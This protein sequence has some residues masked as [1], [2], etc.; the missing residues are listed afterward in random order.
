[1]NTIVNARS[2]FKNHMIDMHTSS[3]QEALVSANIN[4]TVEKLTVTADVLTPEG[5]TRI[6]MPDNKGIVARFPDEIRPFRTVGKD[7]EVIQNADA[8]GPLQYLIGEG[9][10]SHITQAG[11]L[12]GGRKVFMLA[13][14]A[15]ESTLVDPHKRMVL[16]ATSHDGSGSLMIKGW[17]KR[18]FCANQIPMIFSNRGD[19]IARIKHS[20]G[21]KAY[22]RQS[23]A[24]VT[25]SIHQMEA[26]EGSMQEMCERA[27]TEWEVT[28]FLNKLFPDPSH[29]ALSNKTTA[30]IKTITE[31]IREKRTTTSRLINGSNNTNIAGT[32][33]SL[34]AGAVEWSD[35]HSRGDAGAR[36]LNGKDVAFKQRA[37]VLAGA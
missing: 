25:A 21:A 19:V 5:V 23:T 24:A 2:P 13:E 14:L 3:V 10:I 4:F 36:I 11:S 30:Q 16:F 32:A 18:L 17:E 9:L 35:Y 28:V 27:I 15:S 29:V 1:M 37:F 33:A 34:F 26:Y 12:H 20:S 6:D 7:Y 8:F 31:R 22:L